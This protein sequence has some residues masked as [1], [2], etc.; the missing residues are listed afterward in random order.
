MALHN[1]LFYF[2]SPDIIISWNFILL[3]ILEDT[4]ALILLFD[5][6]EARKIWQSRLQGAIYRASVLLVLFFFLVNFFITYL[7][8]VGIH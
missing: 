2:R 7:S 8:F 1:I 3:Q 4:G 6:E 5:N